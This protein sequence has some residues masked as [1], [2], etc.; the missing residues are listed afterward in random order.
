M[1]A[2]NVNATQRMTIFGVQMFL[3]R[4]LTSC[5]EKWRKSALRHS[6]HILK[7]RST[8]RQVIAHLTFPESLVIT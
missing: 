7:C 1:S 6:S 5:F 2:L 4:Y 8:G 3:A